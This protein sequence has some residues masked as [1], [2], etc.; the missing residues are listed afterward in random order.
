MYFDIDD[1]NLLEKYKTIWTNI[2]NVQNM[3]FN[4]L[5]VYD[6][7]YIQTK[8]RAQDDKMCTNVYSL[9]GTEDGVECES[10]TTIL[11][12]LYFFMKTNST[13]KYIQTMVLIEFQTS[14]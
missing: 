10:F 11:L 2:Q 5:T 8:I 7:R 1:D 3:K 13:R 14:K 12:I 9:N 4:D 6:D